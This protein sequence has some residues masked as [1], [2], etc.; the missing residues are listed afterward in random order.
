MEIKRTAALKCP[1]GR[2]KAEGRRA[3]GPCDLARPASTSS[4]GPIHDWE[5]TSARAGDVMSIE[6]GHGSILR[7]RS[8]VGPV[9][10]VIRGVKRMFP[11]HLLIE[12]SRRDPFAAHCPSVRP[13]GG[14]RRGAWKAQHPWVVP[15]TGVGTHN[16][17]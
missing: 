2:R 4:F 15:G 12:S 1:R 14:A 7:H 3:L 10:N 9:P 8:I 17:S 16:A 6:K 13:V 11:A 5:K